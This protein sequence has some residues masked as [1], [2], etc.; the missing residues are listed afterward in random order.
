MSRI[1]SIMICIVTLGAPVHGFAGSVSERSMEDPNVTGVTT[2]KDI[3]LKIRIPG[4][5]GD[6][7]AVDIV[8]AKGR[9]AVTKG[10]RC[11]EGEL[12]TSQRDT[13]AKASERFV[14]NPG[15]FFIGDTEVC[16]G[17]AIV[18]TVC[19]KK[20]VRCAFFRGGGRALCSPEFD[21]LL[22]TLQK[23]LMPR[24]PKDEVEGSVKAALGTVRSRCI[25]TVDFDQKYSDDVRKQ[26]MKS[27]VII[28]N[29]TMKEL[30]ENIS[31]LKDP[32]WSERWIVTGLYCL[33]AA[34]RESVGQLIYDELKEHPKWSLTTRVQ[35][36]DAS[37]SG[38]CTKGLE[39]YEKLLKAVEPNTYHYGYDADRFI[40]RVCATDV[41]ERAIKEEKLGRLNI[42]T[43]PRALAWLTKHRS[44]LE[45]DENVGRFR[46][47]MSDGRGEEREGQGQ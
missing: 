3:V 26:V 45:F 33:A 20:Q 2:E 10:E 19:C 5:P 16:D 13:V 31:G 25:S 6:P 43:A 39:E 9:I 23:A 37:I 34:W 14:E 36:L 11:Y 38:G 28:E 7:I 35:V 15:P 18:V 17:V 24:V 27:V 1:M 22:T 42:G 12:T 47:R 32:R 4:M 21:L 29:G 41:I 30:V 46:L 8:I 40:R 44:I